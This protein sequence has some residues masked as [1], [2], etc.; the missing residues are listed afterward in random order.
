VWAP[1]YAFNLYSTKPF[2][3]SKDEVGYEI[4]RMRKEDAF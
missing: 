3:L 1:T 4:E 2:R